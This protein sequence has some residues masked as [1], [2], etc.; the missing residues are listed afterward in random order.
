VFPYYG[1]DSPTKVPLAVGLKKPGSAVSLSAILK[2]VT[3][4]QSLLRP[5]FIATSGLRFAA[6]FLSDSSGCPIW[7]DELQKRCIGIG[8]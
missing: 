7:L 6:A 3:R 5:S 4:L 1:L 8:P 2:L